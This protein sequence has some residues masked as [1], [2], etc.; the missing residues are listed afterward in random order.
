MKR[1]NDI[2]RSFGEKLSIHDHLCWLIKRLSSME[3]TDFI[4]VPDKL[5][6]NTTHQKKKVRH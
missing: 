2:I 4:T 5:Q 1:E 6:I 3:K